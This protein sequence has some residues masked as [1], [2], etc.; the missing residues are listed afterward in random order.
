M[1]VDLQGT[2]LRDRFWTYSAKTQDNLN[3][4]STTLIHYINA[5]CEADEE[6]ARDLYEAVVSHDQQL[7]IQRQFGEPVGPSLPLPDLDNPDQVLDVP[8]RAPAQRPPG[9]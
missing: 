9:A 4:T 6:N 3:D 2:S 5:V 8:E 1:K 7:E